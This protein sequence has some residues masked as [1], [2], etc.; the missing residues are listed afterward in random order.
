M[1]IS[2]F[3]CLISL[4]CCILCSCMDK[5]VVYRSYQ[6]VSP[7]GWQRDD[8]LR[9]NIHIPDSG[10]NYQTYLLIR[11]LDAY[12][13]QNL[14]LAIKYPKDSL[15]FQTDT[16]YFNFAHKDREQLANEWGGLRQTLVLIDEKEIQRPDTFT[17]KVVSLMEDTELPGIN[18][19]GI[20]MER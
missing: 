15:N 3:L 19:M 17:F 18:D 4:F 2:R 1:R 16:L 5:A 10:F 7:N 12:P 6:P 11:T 13:Y 8:T 14:V 9:F 20:I